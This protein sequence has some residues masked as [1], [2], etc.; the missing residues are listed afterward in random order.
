[1]KRLILFICI[2]STH[3]YARS[4]HEPY[5]KWR[6]NSELWKPSDY[7]WSLSF[8]FDSDKF[9]GRISG[10]MNNRNNMVEINDGDVVFVLYLDLKYFAEKVFPN[11]KNKFIL[12]VGFGDMNFPSSF[13]VNPDLMNMFNSD[14]IIHIY[15]VNFDQ[16]GF[17]EKA[18][19]LP[20]GIDFKY[21]AIR[22][23]RHETE[24]RNPQQNEVLLK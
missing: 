22:R 3:A 14:K 18:S 10:V 16:T 15:A 7:V 11:V 6:N 19:H 4:V 12:L 17:L 8:A 20:L 5:G 9:F 13:L 21:S 1:M 24:S 2:I 23:P